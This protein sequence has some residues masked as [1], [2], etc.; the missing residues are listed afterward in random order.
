MFISPNH[1]TDIEQW[2]SDCIAGIELRI[3]LRSAELY[4]TNIH[5]KFKT[6]PIEMHEMILNYAQ[7]SSKLYRAFD[8]ICKYDESSVIEPITNEVP[9]PF[10]P[11]NQSGK[12]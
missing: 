5:L 3:A 6:F 11:M 12:C 8:S 9:F 7:K 4:F 1:V 2:P 10:H